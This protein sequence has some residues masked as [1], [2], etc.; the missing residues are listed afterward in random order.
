[1]CIRDSGG[2][3]RGP[4]ATAWD[5]ANR[6]DAGVCWA[7]A[8][9]DVVDLECDIVTQ[10]CSLHLTIET[11]W[12]LVWFTTPFIVLAGGG[13]VVIIGQKTLRETLGIDVM[14]QLKASVLN[15]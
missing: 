14:V 11:P 1:M 9:G 12:A 5:D 13:D 3:G 6:V 8:C 10:S 7:C 4:A 15:H 2:A